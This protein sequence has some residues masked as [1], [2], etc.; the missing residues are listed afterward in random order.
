MT[1]V[2]CQPP[3]EASISSGHGGAWRVGSMMMGW[4]ECW[5]RPCIQVGLLQE[6]DLCPFSLVLHHE[7]ISVP[8]DRLI[9]FPGLSLSP[10]F[11]TRPHTG[12]LDCLR[13]RVLS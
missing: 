5:G 2:L 8:R 6:M 11:S 10:Y 9:I 4:A 7:S 12:F 3:G 13:E 1:G